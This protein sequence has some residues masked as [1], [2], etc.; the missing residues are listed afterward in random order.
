M[1]IDLQFL[2][3]S[4]IAS[5]DLRTVFLK[6]ELEKK[7][8]AFEKN[9]I[10]ID[11]N[12]KEAKD[13]LAY[14]KAEKLR[15]YTML[16]STQ[17]ESIKK[18]LNSFIEHINKTLP[19]RYRNETPNKKQ[20][21]GRILGEQL[22]PYYILRL[23]SLFSRLDCRNDIEYKRLVESAEILTGKSTISESNVLPSSYKEQYLYIGLGSLV[24]LVG[25]Y[26]IAKKE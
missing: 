24:L 15:G 2:Y 11:A 22:L 20:F 7:Y 25:L 23:E 19:Q 12:I 17:P 18:L 10:K 14:L 3:D 4:G 1:A 26:I 21:L 6:Q 9:C 5:Q 8:S 16:E 13:D